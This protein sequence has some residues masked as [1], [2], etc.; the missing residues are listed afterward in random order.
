[1]GVAHINHKFLES[2]IVGQ[3]HRLLATMRQSLPAVEPLLVEDHCR[4]PGAA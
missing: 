1:M 4:V 3:I 2:I